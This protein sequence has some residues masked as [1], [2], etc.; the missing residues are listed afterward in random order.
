MLLNLSILDFVIVDK[1]S[2]DFKSGFS[3]LTGETGAGKSI[4]I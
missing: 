1:M 4:L 2:L 3:A